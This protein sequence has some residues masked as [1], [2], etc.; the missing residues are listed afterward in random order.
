MKTDFTQSEEK[1]K[2]KEKSEDSFRILWGKIMWTMSLWAY[3][4]TTNAQMKLMCSMALE[5]S[6]IPILH[7]KEIPV[8]LLESV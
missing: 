3:P 2:K 8:I 5:Y 7:I 6:V 4:N 1:K